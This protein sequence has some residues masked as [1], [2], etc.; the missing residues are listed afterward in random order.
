[1][2]EPG[3]AQTP[4][5]AEPCGGIPATELRPSYFTPLRLMYPSTECRGAAVRRNSGRSAPR[6]SLTAATLQ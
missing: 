2:A 4:E 6:E 3:A 1:M 5:T